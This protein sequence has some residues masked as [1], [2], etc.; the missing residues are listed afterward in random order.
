[1][2]LNCFN[3]LK[4]KS[5]PELKYWFSKLNHDDVNDKNTQTRVQK[6]KE[7]TEFI[8]KY[9]KCKNLK[10]YNGIYVLTDVL[11]LS[12]FISYRL[13]SHKIFGIDPINSVFLPGFFNRAMFKYTQNEIELFT[14]KDMYLTAQI[15]MRSG[16][17]EVAVKYAEA[18][19]K[20]INN[21][22][23]KKL[24]TYLQSLDANS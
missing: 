7:Y 1:M 11:L 3:K 14:N 6:E 5:L 10:D 17:C 19:N 12:V 13:R 24:G 16:R 4:E 2:D 18:N 22:F 15:G 8:L 23:N 20:Y 9:F 21:N